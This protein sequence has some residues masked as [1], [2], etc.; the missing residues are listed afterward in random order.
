MKDKK[1]FKDP[2]DILREGYDP[3]I[4]RKVI[5]KKITIKL[6]IVKYNE[7]GIQR[8]GTDSIWIITY[9]SEEIM[10]KSKDIDKP[11]SPFNIG[12]WINN[13]IKM[14]LEDLIK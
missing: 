7:A 4:I 5:R 1:I 12:I 8:A 10:V 14:D 9:N 2:Q 13:K 3:L 11:E 6:E